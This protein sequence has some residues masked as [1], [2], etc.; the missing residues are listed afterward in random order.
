MDQSNQ[1]NETVAMEFFRLL[2]SDDFENMRNL[3][4]DDVEWFAQTSELPGDF[5]GNDAVIEEML[6]PYSALFEVKLTNEIL[7]VATNGPLVIVESRGKG[8]LRDG[9]SYENRYAWAFE[10]RDGKISVIREYMDSAYVVRMLG[11]QSVVELANS[12]G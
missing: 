9:R 8:V 5:Q 2:D 10:I 3:L 12:T 7:S 11:Q 1:Q 4:A 6:K